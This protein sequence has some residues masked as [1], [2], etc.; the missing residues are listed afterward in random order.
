M[1]KAEEFLQKERTATVLRRAKAD[2]H[3]RLH[4]G[5][6][7]P[8]VDKWGFGFNCD[9]RFEAFS[10]NVALDSWTGHYGSSSCSTFL[11][12]PDRDAA[13]AAFVEYLNLHV[14]EIV[15]GMADII[16][17]G[18]GDAKAAYIEELRAELERLIPQG[19]EAQ[20]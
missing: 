3:A 11:N 5:G 14:W 16:D 15:E 1:S 20:P 2:Y 19:Q 7:G 9:D 12:L 4:E 8:R 6:S 10:V 13:K 18:N 17:K